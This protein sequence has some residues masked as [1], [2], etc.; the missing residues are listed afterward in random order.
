[1]NAR[2][3]IIFLFWFLTL[4]CLGQL[5]SQSATY[6]PNT[7]SLEKRATPQWFKNAKLGI[8]IHWG[9]YSVPAWATPTTTPDKVTDWRAFYKSNP[10]AEWYLNS[11]RI[12]GSPT[13]L[14][15]EKVY[16]KNYNY[17]YFKDSLMHKTVKWN[18]VSWANLF[19]KIGAKYVVLTSKHHDGFTLYP[20]KIANPFMAKNVIN[21]SRDFVGELA[22]AVRKKGLKY[23][24][25]YSGGLDWTFNQDPITN[26]WPDL[27]E[28]MPKSMDYTAYADGHLKELIRNYKPDILWNDI[29]YPKNGDLL[30]IFAEL[31]NSNSN[32]V[33]NERWGQYQSLTNFT[34]P[35]YQVLDSIEKNKWETCRGIG[36][37]FG[38]NQVENDAHL[39]SSTALV[40]LLIDIVSKN[41]N[42]LLNIGP[43]ADG[44][45]PENQLQRLMDLGKWMKIYSEGIYDTHPYRV[46][47]LKLSDGTPLRFTQKQNNLYIFLFSKPNNKTL[48]IPS[49][50]V[51]P[52]AQIL[53][54]GK[55][56]IPLSYTIE[57]NGILIKLPPNFGLEHAAMIRIKG[58]IHSEH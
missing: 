35:E 15:H 12:N 37:S 47:S 58:L 1:M 41:G 45:I 56:N 3:I 38:Y 55:Y 53:L 36:Y 43:K 14:H 32:A 39:L 8:F 22:T 11:L 21:S 46:A 54:Y 16:G 31:F 25:Y 51:I 27:F 40:Q 10:Y 20:S 13:Q 30:N 42:L 44:T 50:K 33:I 49:C 2:L 34:T 57:G 17:Y 23:G 5:K 24:I 52:S 6:L 19:S 29:N 28:A 26:L 4:F 9:L 7:A 18:A 48:F